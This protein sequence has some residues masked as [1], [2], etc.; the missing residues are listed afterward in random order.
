MRHRISLMMAVLCLAPCGAGAESVPGPA[1]AQTEGDPATL[2]FAEAV[3]AC[4]AATFESPH[5]FMRGFIIPHRIVGPADGKCVYSQ[6]MPGD[7]RM[8]CSLSEEGQAALAAEFREQAAGRM[9][10][11]TAKQPV[12]AKECSIIGKDGKATP[13]GG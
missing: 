13:M 4:E 3:Q 1:A 10:G 6:G 5:P 2:A 7:M 9:S 8:E 12:W 11:S